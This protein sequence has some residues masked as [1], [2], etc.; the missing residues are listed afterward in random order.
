MQIDSTATAKIVDLTHE[1][2][3]VADVDGRK[4][5]VAGALPGEDVVIALQKGRRRIALG[6]QDAMSRP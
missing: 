5:F 6:Y 3:G 1:G 4:L 2:K